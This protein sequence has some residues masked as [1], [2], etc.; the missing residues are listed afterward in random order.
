MEFEANGRALVT[1]FRWFLMGFC[2]FWE[3]KTEEK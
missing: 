1:G 2:G 3:D